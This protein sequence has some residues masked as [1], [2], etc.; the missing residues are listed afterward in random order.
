MKEILLRRGIS[1]DDGTFGILD[2]SGRHFRTAELPWRENK[3]NIS[4]IPEGSYR[5]KAYKS[6]KFGDCFKLMDVPGRTDVLIH[7]GNYAGDIYKG[8][9]SDVQGCILIG[10]D[11][12]SINIGGKKQRMVTNSRKKFAEF[13]SLAGK[14]DFLL[15]ISGNVQYRG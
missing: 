12:I 4:C 9:K 11:V 13:M 2:L 8:Y 10:E 7:V 5:V 15:I 6:P 3:S 14:E 1:A